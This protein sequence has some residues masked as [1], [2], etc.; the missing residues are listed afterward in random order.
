VFNPNIGK[1]AVAI[2]L[3]IQISQK[4]I[5]S[6]ILTTYKVHRNK[7]RYLLGGRDGQGKHSSMRN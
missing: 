1:L 2:L 7:T 4:V 3:A 5:V 6:I